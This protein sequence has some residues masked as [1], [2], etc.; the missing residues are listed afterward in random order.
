MTTTTDEKG[1]M[2]NFAREPKMYYAEAPSSNEQRRYVLWG[3][4][5][6][7]VIAA[8]VFTAVVAS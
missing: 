6:T 4:I 5:A 1:I 8:S 2:N 7:V 3:A